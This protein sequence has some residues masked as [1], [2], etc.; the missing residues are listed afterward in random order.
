MKHIK[1]FESFINEGK[2]TYGDVYSEPGFNLMQKDLEEVLGKYAFDYFIDNPKSKQV[3]Y[4]I[5][6][7]DG[8]VSVTIYR[9]Y[10][11]YFGKFYLYIYSKKLKPNT[12]TIKLKDKNELNDILGKVAKLFNVMS[13]KQ[14][15]MKKQ[16]DEL[17][18][19]LEDLLYMYGDS[20]EEQKAARN[21]SKFK[22]LAKKVDALQAKYNKTYE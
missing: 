1:L 15:A 9:D 8:G 12:Q 5:E 16:L 21:T 11:N 14:A 20:D 18:Y 17:N 13:P 6:G 4:K 22:S 7:L 10:S 2:L 19:K 3:E